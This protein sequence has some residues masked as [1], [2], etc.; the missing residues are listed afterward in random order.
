MTGCSAADGRLPRHV[1]ATPPSPLVN[2]PLAVTGRFVMPG[3]RRRS[4]WWVEGQHRASPGGL[5][6]AEQLSTQRAAT[7]AWITDGIRDRA[8][9]REGI[10][11]RPPQHAE[12]PYLHGIR[13][14]PARPDRH[15][16][17]RLGAHAPGAGQIIE[18]DVEPG[19]PRGRNAE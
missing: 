17:R 19:R 14:H 13:G 6:L 8:A 2:D 18:S 16:E 9:L 1:T 5:I 11:R 3:L 15:T 12:P 7:L 4:G 10:T